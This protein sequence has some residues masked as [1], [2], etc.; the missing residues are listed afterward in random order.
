MKKR[1]ITLIA[2]I[3][4]VIAFVVTGCQKQGATYAVIGG[5]YKVTDAD[6]NQY[7]VQIGAPSNISADQK[8]AVI[9]NLI[10]IKL[11]D[12]VGMQKGYEKSS[13][14]QTMMTSQQ[15]QILSQVA[16]QKYITNAAKVTDQDVSSAYNAQKSQLSVPQQAVVSHIVVKTKAQAQAIIS[17]LQ[18]KSGT[19]LDNA[20]SAIAKTQSLDTQT[21]QKGGLIG[22]YSQSNAIGAYKAAI[23]SM[24]SP[25]VYSKPVQLMGDWSVIKVNQIIPAQAMSLTQATPMLKQQLQ[26]QKFIQQMQSFQTSSIKRFGS[27]NQ[28]NVNA[29]ISGTAVITSGSS[30]VFATINGQNITGQDLISAVSTMAQQQTGQAISPAAA[31]QYIAQM[32]SQAKQQVF[33]QVMLNK[34]LLASAK[35]DN[36][37]NSKDYKQIYAMISSQALAMV[38]QQKEIVNN[39][40]ITDAQAQSFYKQYSSQINQPFTQVKAQ[41]VQMLQQQESA[42]AIQQWFVANEAKYVKINKKAMPQASLPISGGDTGGG[43]ASGSSN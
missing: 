33:S 16:M 40:Q 36:L 2:I 28:A 4:I 18:G 32:N 29:F 31:V 15:N 22:T 37:Q 42:Q 38:T 20:F 9:N 12:Y 41:I 43:V 1:Y 6:V 35:K 8:L 13:D 11:L 19:V 10:Y 24:T 17:Q 5:K 26:Q 34:L 21:A 30:T 3:V 14:Y 27:E 7:L 39:I 23:F 25:G